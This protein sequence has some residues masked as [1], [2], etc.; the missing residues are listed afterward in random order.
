VNILITGGTGFFGRAFLDFVITN[1]L[2]ST[3]HFFLTSRNPDHFLRQHKQYNS[4][5]INFIQHN[6]LEE[7]LKKKIDVDVDVIVHAAAN[8]SKEQIENKFLELNT[9]TQGISN[10]INFA[11]NH[12]SLKKFIFLSSGAVYGNID[13]HEP[14]NEECPLCEDFNVLDEYAIGKV[15][16]EKLINKYL[17]PSKIVTVTLRLFSFIG[18]YLP[19]DKHFAVMNFI[20]DALHEEVIKV[21]SVNDVY[22]TFLDQ[23]DMASWIW[24]VLSECNISNIYNLGSDWEYSIYDLANL[25]KAQISPDKQVIFTNKINPSRIFYTPN[26]S[27]IKNDFGLFEALNLQ[28]SIQNIAKIYI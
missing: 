28:K 11:L 4:K 23:Q 6:I 21:N 8:S 3:N 7:N 15:I 25:I 1:K 16:S 17:V 12:R 5:N 24:T 22:R 13:K 26:V 20:N 2:N 19:L 27:K 18:S 9:H 10:I 14:I